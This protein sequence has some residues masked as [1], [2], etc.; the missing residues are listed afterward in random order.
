MSVV[1]W[2]VLMVDCWVENEDSG[3]KG[4]KSGEAVEA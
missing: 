1:N 3:S 2:P 4:E